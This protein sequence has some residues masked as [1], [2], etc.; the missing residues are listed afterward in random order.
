MLADFYYA[1]DWPSDFPKNLSLG[2]SDKLFSY[3]L[4]AM[5]S[6]YYGLY[7]YAKVWM[8]YVSNVNLSKKE[9]EQW[10][11]INIKCVCVIYRIT[12]LCILTN[13]HCCQYMFS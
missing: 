3:L 2:E 4:N 13:S 8:W 6:D 9:S 10:K 1:C 12:L 11:T 7:V 5:F